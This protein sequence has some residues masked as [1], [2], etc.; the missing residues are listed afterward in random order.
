MPQVAI[1]SKLRQFMVET[2]R[3][4]QVGLVEEGRATGRRLVN[5]HKAVVSDWSPPKPS[6]SFRVT[7]KRG[8]VRV[9]VFPRGASRQKYRWLDLGTKGPY[10]IAALVKPY[11]VFQYGYSAKTAPGGKFNVGTGGTTGGWAKK[12]VITHP[13]IPARKFSETFNEEELP[14]FRRN[15]NNMFRRV[16]RRKG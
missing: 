9:T 14:V 7:S 6:F 16:L 4:V 8:F 2:D 13:G 15:V 3:Q 12:K 1:R 10:L 5:K 11:L